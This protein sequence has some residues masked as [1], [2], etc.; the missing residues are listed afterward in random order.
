MR[1]REYP[2]EEFARIIGQKNFQMIAML[3]NELIALKHDLKACQIAQESDLTLGDL[4]ADSGLSFYGSLEYFANEMS[5]LE[6]YC[7]KKMDNY[8]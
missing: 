6:K 3:S 8:S 1:L 4:T 5:H 2:A 7:D